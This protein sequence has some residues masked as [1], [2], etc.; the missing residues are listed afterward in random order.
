M[1]LSA[2][3]ISS[4]LGGVSQVAR[5]LRPASA[6]EEQIN[7][8]SRVSNGGP[9]KRPGTE[10]KAKATSTITGFASGFVHPIHLSSS[11]RFLL[12]IANETLRVF[13][14]TTGVA[15][16]VL[17]P[18]GQA[19]LTIQP[20]DPVTHVVDLH[21][22][23]NG[24][25][26]S[27]FTAT[28]E[29]GFLKQGTEPNTQ[30]RAFNGNA[31]SWGN[32]SIP[33]DKG[34][35]YLWPV[36]SAD[37]KIVANYTFP[38]PRGANDYHGVSVRG[39]LANAGKYTAVINVAGQW[40]L[41]RYSTVGSATLLQSG[42]VVG[43]DASK[44]HTVGLR[45]QGTSLFV[46]LDGVEQSP[47]VDATYSAAGYAGI[48]GS[49]AGDNNGSDGV[50]TRSIM[51][52]FT[53]SYD[54]PAL[55][56]ADKYRAVTVDR[57]TYIVN[58]TQKALRAATKA[59][60]QTPQAVL[61][62]DQADYGTTYS[63]TIDGVTVSYETAAGTDAATRR[64]IATNE[65]AGSI[66]ELLTATFGSFQFDQFGSL[67]RV[68]RTDKAEFNISGQDGLADNGLRVV[69]GTVQSAAELPLRCIDGFVLEVVGSPESAMDTYWVKFDASGA[70]DYRG[71]WK[72]CARPG[73]GVA[74]NPLTLPHELVYSDELTAEVNNR[75]FPKMPVVVPQNP[76]KDF[77]SWE[78]TLNGGDI[79]NTALPILKNH[80]DDL[81]VNLEDTNGGPIKFAF[82]YLVNTTKMTSGESLILTVAVNNGP[83]STTW[84]TVK[85]LTFSPGLYLKDQVLEAEINTP[86][87]A[88]WDVR[89]LVQYDSG[90]TPATPGYVGFGRNQ[91]G[92]WY[93]NY[94]AQDVTWPTDTVYPKGTA[95]TITVDGTPANY[96]QTADMTGA[97]IAAVMEPIVEALAGYTSSVVTNDKGTAIR[98]T[99]DAG[100]LPVVSV[101]KVF[102]VATHFWN[103]DLKLESATDTYV[104]KTL[105]NLSDG[106]QG[107]IT[108]SYATGVTVDALTGG[109]DNKFSDGDTCII[110]DDESRWVFRPL[111]WKDRAAGDSVTNPWPS[112]RD[113]RI[114]EVLYHRGRLGMLAG[115]NVVLSE[116]GVPEN[117]FRTATV[118]LLD[119]DPIDVKPASAG[120][121]A[122]TA[123]VEWD[124][125][126]LLF[127][128][129]AQYELS[130]DPL[131]TPSSVS[132]RLLSRYTGSPIRPVVIGSRLYFAR[133]LERFTRLF[134]YKGVPASER[135]DAEDITLSVPR[136]LTGDPVALAG[137]SSLGVLAALVTGDQSRLYVCFLRHEDDEPVQ[138][139]WS[140]WQ[141]DSAATV[142]GMDFMDG[143]LALLVQRADGVF[144]ETMD[145]DEIITTGYLLDRRITSAFAGV[146][147]TFSAGET[148][149]TLPYSVATNGTAGVVQVVDAAGN[150]LTTSRPSATTVKAT[151]DYTAQ[152]VTIGLQY[153][154]EVDPSTLYMRD[155]D[156]VAE[157]RGRTQVR[158]I[159]LTYSR[160][161]GFTVTVTP[162]GRTAK[163]YTVSKATETEGE[164][165]V[166]V[167]AENEQVSITI[168][169]ATPFPTR[170][171]GLDWE[172][173]YTAR[174]QR[175]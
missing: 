86:V 148:T 30:F 24:T 121:A 12:T 45:V 88:N 155:R 51:S 81:Y 91:V 72:E 33:V 75:A 90:A 112:L 22:A 165:R 144:L 43:Y 131:L 46:I 174:G 159:T 23:V 20:E 100:G 60:V 105:K 52:G 167:Q 38:S 117:L 115:G 44:P 143:S 141:F 169:N 2:Q 89:V 101:S 66:R 152:T 14:R 56:S 78:A 87:G 98:I 145:L 59:A 28:T 107:L 65:I 57:K 73:E 114:S 63:V 147:P 9:S 142:I 40:S 136:Y 171:T 118:Q 47:I 77:E 37:Y 58:T 173:L 122:F 111:K 133:A 83:S 41:Q 82:S 132:L 94:S 25:L 18:S 79:S 175:V 80:N 134:E 106:S 31:L 130:G 76:V 70:D 160:T 39:N 162:T 123:A 170:L 36:P 19:Y 127:T 29:F 138:V 64:L 42:T 109:T 67:I 61:Y 168:T 4:L 55:V 149:W 120:T 157:T 8:L 7:G 150:V 50:A 15:Q 11:Q 125:R 124:N 140:R 102:S 154:F 10:H 139:A 137:D 53:I 6:V 71:V 96:T 116:A 35:N 166:P 163:T 92:V 48:V 27:A 34:Y 113:R 119:S 164:L 158:S 99:K 103:P 1:P 172:F 126:L 151:G 84:T 21:S 135:M 69:K 95:W 17:F 68:M 26:L 93:F 104:G 85:T 128:D 32:A 129:S 54:Q 49:G 146:S 16:G 74:F 108:A 62:V 110:V 156:G 13:D 97:A 5:R 153:L 3:R 161:R